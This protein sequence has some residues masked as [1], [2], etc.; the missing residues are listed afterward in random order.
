V[1]DLDDANVHHLLCKA[2]VSQNDDENTVTIVPAESGV[3]VIKM[4]K[5]TYVYSDFAEFTAKLETVLDG[6]N[7]MKRLF[8]TGGYEA[9]SGLLTTTYL[10]VELK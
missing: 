10:T 5:N 7:R 3:Y 4:R 1:V 2:H 9:D 6:Y 8:A